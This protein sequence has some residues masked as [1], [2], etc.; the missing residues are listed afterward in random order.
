MNLYP[1]LLLKIYEFLT[2]N[3][4]SGMP[5]TEEDQYMLDLGIS[6]LRDIFSGRQDFTPM[7]EVVGLQEG[8]SDKSG[9]LGSK[10]S[11]RDDLR[12]RAPRSTVGLGRD[13]EKLEIAISVLTK[14]RNGQA[15]RRIRP[16]EKFDQTVELI[17]Q[18]TRQAFAQIDRAPHGGRTWLTAN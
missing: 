8:S 17:E 3:E 14:I 5:I 10:V 6:H 15:I 12:L 4:S 18:L 1:A 13:K 7:M 9:V 2:Q 16:R 11:V